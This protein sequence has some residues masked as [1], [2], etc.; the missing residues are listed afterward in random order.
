MSQLLTWR[1]LTAMVDTA[2]SPNSF[3]KNLLFTDH[4]SVPTET[5]EIPL[6]TKAREAAPFVRK[7]GEALMVAGVGQ[8]SSLVDA[9]NIRIKKPFNPSQVLFGRLPGTIQYARTGQDLTQQASLKVARDMQV[10]ADMMTNSEEYMC[11]GALQGVTSISVE[12]AENFTITFPRPG[13]CNISASVFWDN[14]DPTLPQPLTDIMAAK[15]AL[16]D[17]SCP[18]PTD[19]LLGSTAATQFVTL[20]Q[21]G[22][23]KLL[24]ALNYISAGDATMIEQ[25]RDDGALFLGNIGGLRFW[26]YGRTCLVNVNGTPTQTPMIRP[27]YMEIVSTSAASDRKL[28]YGA[29]ADVDALDGWLFQ[30]ERFAKSWK[31]PDPS[32]LIALA[33]TRPLPVP[34][35]PGATCSVKVISGA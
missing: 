25:F 27:K 15:Q 24:Q 30:G 1:S 28:Y 13:N 29:I 18:T 21:K 23:I 11:A 4:E 16:S 5:I 19:A 3:L 22:G 31:Q 20:L 33:H 17:N 34:R 9:P 12:D 14:A 35:R 7:N 10:L 26:Q 2:Q 8:T 32:A 6:F